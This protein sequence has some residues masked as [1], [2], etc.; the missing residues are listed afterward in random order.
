MTKNRIREIKT[1]K[2]IMRIQI[3][4]KKLAYTIN[5]TM[6]LCIGV[7]VALSFFGCSSNDNNSSGNLMEATDSVGKPARADSIKEQKKDNLK[8]AMVGDIMMGTTYPEG[9]T[10]LTADDGATLFQDAKEILKRVD[11]AAGNLEGCLFDG[12]GKLKPRNHA[13]RFFAFKMPERYGKHLVDAGFDFVSIANNHINDFGPEALAATQRVLQESGIAYAGLT[14]THPTAILE[15][16][17]RKIGFTA[18]GFDDRMPY[19]NNFEQIDSIISRL[20]GQCDFVVVSFHGGGEGAGYQHVPHKKE[21]TS[22]DRGDVEKFA[23]A[24]VNAGADVVY[25]HSPH[26]PR[27]LE[28]YNDRIIFYSL[29]NFCTPHMFNLEGVCGYAP[30]AEVMLNAD[31]SFAS[32]RIHSFVQTRG[33]GPRLDSTNRAARKMR[34]LTKA[35]FPTTPLNISD[36]G[37]ITVKNK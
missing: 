3:N 18:F 8:L 1:N 15:R 22:K 20:K 12:E 29:G 36:D 26:V 31:G 11:V 27:A 28:L 4:L 30:L 25:G 10:N 14:D 16:N 21:I 5:S 13:Y 24:A 2:N 37:E 9:G 17:G 23:H 6:N 34:E 32:G 7:T 35:D 19:I 33:V